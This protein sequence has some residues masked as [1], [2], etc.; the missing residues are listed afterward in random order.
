MVY[1]DLIT[2]FLDLR[3]LLFQAR[4][5]SLDFLLL[6]SATGLQLRNGRSLFLNLALLLF[7]HAVF[8]EEL[9]KHHGIEIQGRYCQSRWSG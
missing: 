2:H 8:L 4:S 5:E 9:V 7:D 1:F 6:L 3:R